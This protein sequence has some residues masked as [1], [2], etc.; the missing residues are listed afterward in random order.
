MNILSGRILKVC[1]YIFTKPKALVLMSNQSVICITAGIYLNLSGFRGWVCKVL[2]L[3][4]I[5]RQRN[6]DTSTRF[7]NTSL[8]TLFQSFTILFT[9]IFS[10]ISNLSLSGASSGHFLSSCQDAILPPGG[11]TEYPHHK[12]LSGGCKE[13][14]GFP[15]ASLSSAPSASSLCS[16]P[17]TRLPPP[18]DKTSILITKSMRGFCQLRTSHK[19]F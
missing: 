9:E 14:Q 11:E 19:H 3:A 5:D 8:G 17:F 4:G 7:L 13:Q 2:Q 15:K 6:P 1:V 10:L 16:S 18:T 12:L